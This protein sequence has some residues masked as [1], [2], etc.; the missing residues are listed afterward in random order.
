MAL[1]KYLEEKKEDKRIEKTT[2]DKIN[3]DETIEETL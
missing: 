1:A 3:F 2:N